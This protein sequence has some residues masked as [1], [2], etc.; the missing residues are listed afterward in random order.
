MSVGAGP[1]LV[2]ILLVE[3]SPEDARLAQEALK[4]GKVANE[5]HVVGD[6]DAAMAFVRQEGEFG[7][8]P[9]P[10]LVLL[11]LN[12]PRK[13]GREVLTEI[14]GDP[15]LRRIPVIVLTTSSS[16]RDV[17]GAYDAHVN[18]YLRKPVNFEQLVEVVHVIDDFWFGVVTLPPT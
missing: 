16:D 1:R 8:A 12:L 9:R 14:K 15:D 13:D 17:L 7:D 2:Q 10:D 11:D 5:L 18:A 6:G 3:D 4:D